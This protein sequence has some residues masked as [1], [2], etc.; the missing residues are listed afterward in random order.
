MM[1]DTIR[2]RIAA[3]C[4]CDVGAAQPW[5]EMFAKPSVSVGFIGGSVTSGFA[6][7]RFYET[8]YPQMLVQ[9]MRD[10]GY[11]VKE[12]VLAAPGMDSMTGNLLCDSYILPHQP[13]LII[14]DFAINEMTQRPSILAFESLL[15]HL[16]TMP[17]PPI[18]CLLLLRSQNDYSC[19][20]F[21]LPMAAHY[22]LACI[23]LRRGLNPALERG[24]LSWEEYG[25]SESHPTP[26]GHRLL[27]DCLLHLLKQARQTE[28]RPHPELPAPWLD[29]PYTA[30][31]F[32]KPDDR[33]L[34]P[35]TDPYFREAL[36]IDKE[37]GAWEMT[38][39][40]KTLLVFYVTHRLPEYG[41]CTVLIDG[42]P[43]KL[44]RM[45][46]SPVLRSNSIYGWGNARYAQLLTAESA[47]EH[48]LR[49]EP[50]DG[51][52]YLLGIGYTD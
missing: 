37:S 42:A 29:A 28:P 14:L 6:A 44:T 24:D 3:D 50:L 26:E 36:C 17:R 51:K 11:H 46:Q 16:L 43:P 20:S 7:D 34:I 40:C 49:L 30:L 25:D 2:A 12:S 32:R 10:M 15:R 1:T 47:A 23:N 31:H 52:F 18:I 27:A 4:L 13:D 21:M 22:G 38:L 48:T 33:P 19:E 8:A 39:R 5:A 35:R 45:L 9:G 41:D